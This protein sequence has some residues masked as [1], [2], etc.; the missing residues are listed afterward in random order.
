MRPRVVGEVRGR[1]RTS[2]SFCGKTLESGLSD[3][4]HEPELSWTE[5]CRDL[6][7]TVWVGCRWWYGPRTTTPVSRAETE[8]RVGDE[9]R[10]LGGE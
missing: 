6:R 9:G 10:H 7:V 4:E 8:V 5:K 2:I 1:V 3:V